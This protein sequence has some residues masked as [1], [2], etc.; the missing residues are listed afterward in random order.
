MLPVNHGIT[1]IPGRSSYP[2]HARRIH[3]RPQQIK[4][5]E[6][7]KKKKDKSKNKIARDKSRGTIKKG[8]S[9]Q[10]R[11]GENLETER[12][13]PFKIMRAN[14]FTIY[15]YKTIDAKEK[16]QRK[17]DKGIRLQDSVIG[18]KPES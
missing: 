2:S 16:I 17:K 12:W 10:R 1:G 5:K 18:P 6:K 14:Q 15:C 9:D 4:K 3:N 8:D 11:P 13:S 7:G